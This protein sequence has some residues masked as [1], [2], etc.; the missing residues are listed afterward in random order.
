MKYT[1]ADGQWCKVEV[2]RYVSHVARAKEVPLLDG[3][4]LRVCDETEPGVIYYSLGSIFSLRWLSDEEGMKASADRVAERAEHDRRAESGAK[5]GRIQNTIRKVVEGNR[6]TLPD[7][8]EGVLRI[9]PD[10]SMLDLDDAFDNLGLDKIE[11]GEVTLYWMDP[12]NCP[13]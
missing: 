9:T 7:I 2:M 6:M 5:I 12:D 1:D 13:F 8:Y 11:C 10:I 3:R 4:A